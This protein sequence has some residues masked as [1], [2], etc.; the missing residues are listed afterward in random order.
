MGFSVKDVVECVGPAPHG[1]SKVRA[2]SALPITP[3]P[4]FLP[5]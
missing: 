2:L 1:R 3:W 4:A 5:D